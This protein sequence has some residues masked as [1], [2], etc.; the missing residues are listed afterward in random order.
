MYPRSWS[1]DGRTLAGDAEFYVLPTS[2][3]ELF[4]L[5]AEGKPQAPSLSRDDRWLTYLEHHD[6]SDV[7]LASLEER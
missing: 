3:T 4:D 6:D 5:F 1:P 7:W 2:V